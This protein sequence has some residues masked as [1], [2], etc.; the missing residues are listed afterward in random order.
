MN[1]RE[2]PNVEADLAERFQVAE[3]NPHGSMIYPQKTRGRLRFTRLT[4]L[5]V[6]PLLLS[7][8]SFSGRTTANFIHC[9]QFVEAAVASGN[10][11]QRRVTPSFREQSDAAKVTK[12]SEIRKGG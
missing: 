11:A 1:Q 9:S 12:T 2:K 8:Q 4:A 10:F 7:R 5:L 3:Q 6:L